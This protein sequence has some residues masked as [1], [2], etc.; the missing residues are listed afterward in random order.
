MKSELIKRILSSVVL[1]PLSLFCIINGSY[2]FIFFLLTIFFITLFEWH[3]LAKKKSYYYYGFLYLIFSFY[4]VY[5]LRNHSN[6][7][8][9]LFLIVTMICVLTDIGGFVFGK[10]FQGPKLT[11]FSPNK[12]YSG[13]MGSYIFAFTLIPSLIFFEIYEQLKII[14]LFFFI[15]LISSISQLGDIFISIFKRISRIKD[16]GNILPGHGG[17]LDRIDGMI[18][19]FPASYFLININFFKIFS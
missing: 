1:I 17:L 10:I 6:N 4:F 12:T 13:L 9:I 15:F 2:I 11:R 3:N 16:T 18:F 19:A 5:E 7:D 8:Y 14:N